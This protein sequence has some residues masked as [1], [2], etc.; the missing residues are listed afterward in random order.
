[1]RTYA[2]VEPAVPTVVTLVVYDDPPPWDPSDV[3]ENK[4]GWPLTDESDTSNV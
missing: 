1:M 3:V 4:N 2:P